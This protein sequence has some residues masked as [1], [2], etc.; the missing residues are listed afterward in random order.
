MAVSARKRRQTRR[1]K[2]RVR[3]DGECLGEVYAFADIT[4]IAL[5][6]QMERETQLDWDDIPDSWIAK[7]VGCAY[8]TLDRLWSHTTRRV[9][10]NTLQ[11]LADACGLPTLVSRIPAAQLRIIG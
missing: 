10:Y 3:K 9:T 11:K 8:S 2:P 6:D 5:R 7:R 1:M 4:Y